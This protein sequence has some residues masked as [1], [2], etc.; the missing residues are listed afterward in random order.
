[1]SEISLVINYQRI[2]LSLQQ[3][4]DDPPALCHW[5][6]DF[7]LRHY[8]CFS[9]QLSVPLQTVNDS[10]R[11]WSCIHRTGTQHFF[12]LLSRSSRRQISAQIPCQA[13]RFTQWSWCN[14]VAQETGAPWVTAV[15]LC[16]HCPG[17]GAS[18]FLIPASWEQQLAA[19][20]QMNTEFPPIKDSFF[21]Y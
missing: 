6:E 15:T 9:S 21:T 5:L 12:H 14:P 19:K 7:A 13:H 16:C 18:A 10:A 17:W 20:N 8:S 4:C 2:P 11:G 3:W 1:M